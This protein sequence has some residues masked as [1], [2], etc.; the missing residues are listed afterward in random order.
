MTMAVAGHDLRLN[1]L[2]APENT[3]HTNP[4]PSESYAYALVSF[5]SY[6]LAS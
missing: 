6:K 1:E 4:S 5:Y 3:G 2:Q